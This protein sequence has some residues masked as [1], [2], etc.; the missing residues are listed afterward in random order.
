VCLQPWLEHP[1]LLLTYSSPVGHHDGCPMGHRP[2]CK[3]IFFLSAGCPTAEILTT[4][5]GSLLR[6]HEG[7]RQSSCA[8]KKEPDWKHH[9]GAPRGGVELRACCEAAETRG[10]MRLNSNPSALRAIGVRAS[11][12]SSAFTPSFMM[13]GLVLNSSSPGSLNQL[14]LA[15]PHDHLA[16][17][18]ACVDAGDAEG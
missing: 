8:P 13:F 6:M 12:A 9:H 2:R 11:V 3:A 15:R 18:A 1:P 10:N 14:W 4:L 16:S 5:L 7:P 17:G